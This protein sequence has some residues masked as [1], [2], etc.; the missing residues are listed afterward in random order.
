MIIINLYKLCVIYCMLYNHPS[1]SYIYIHICIGYGPG[2]V[3]VDAHTH[4]D[5]AAL[6]RPPVEAH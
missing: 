6:G 5:S 3:R 2:K 1:H 4:S